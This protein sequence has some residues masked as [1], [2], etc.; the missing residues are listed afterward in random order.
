MADPFH[1]ATSSVK[2]WGGEVADY[3]PVH[4]WFDESKGFYLDARHRALRH[5][6]EGILLS[7]HFFGPTITLKNGCQIPVRWIGEQ[8]VREDLG[9][10]PTVKDWLQHLVTQPWMISPQRLHRTLSL[11]CPTPPPSSAAPTSNLSHEPHTPRDTA[12]IRTASSASPTP[13][14]PS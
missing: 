13:S 2:N 7:I 5:H 8:H 12:L 9:W 4:Q 1:H 10:I 14:V 3:L 11:P 6:S